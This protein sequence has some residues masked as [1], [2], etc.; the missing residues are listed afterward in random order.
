[1]TLRYLGELVHSIQPTYLCATM[2]DFVTETV[3]D[4]NHAD[5]QCGWVKNLIGIQRYTYNRERERERERVKELHHTKYE[6]ATQ[7]RLDSDVCCIV[8]EYHDT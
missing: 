1:M 6:V 4:A 2:T 7:Y 8:H 3:T 5:R